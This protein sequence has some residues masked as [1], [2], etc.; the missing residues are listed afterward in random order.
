[1][2]GEIQ[3]GAKILHKNERCCL[4][5]RLSWYSAC[6]ACMKPWVRSPASHERSEGTHTCNST[7]LEVEA[8]GSRVQDFTSPQPEWPSLRNKHQTSKM[9]YQGEVLATKPH[10]QSSTPGPTSGG[11]NQ[12]VYI[13][14]SGPGRATHGSLVRKT[15][16]D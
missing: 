16:E 3:Q 2:C 1:M 14:S 11:N 15:N 13:V 9:T 12:L 8:A 10:S 5:L 4:G 7:I 6:P